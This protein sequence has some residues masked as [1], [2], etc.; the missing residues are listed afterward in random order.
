MVEDRFRVELLELLEPDT[1][2]VVW[3]DGHESLYPYVLLRAR[4]TCARCVDEWT[5]EE[6]LAVDRIPADIRVDR[7]EATGRYGINLFF[8]DGHTT[9]IYTLKRLREFCPCQECRAGP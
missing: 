1:M 4:C 6:I 5:G 2:L 3:S 8:S 9:G 7:W